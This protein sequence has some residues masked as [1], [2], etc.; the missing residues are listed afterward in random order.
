MIN[1]FNDLKESQN[2]E[3]IPENYEIKEL[4]SFLRDVKKYHLTQVDVEELKSELK[5]RPPKACI[6]RSV[7]KF[8]W[9]P[10]RFNLGKKQGR[11]IYIDIIQGEN[12]YLTALYQ[13]NDKKD[14]TFSEKECILQ[15]S[16][17]KN[18]KHD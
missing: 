10:K 6:G 1:F 4:S 16:R 14:L 7:Y 18:I 9:W 15:L 8:E 12:A 5:K 3:P 17:E 2:L 13:K 11:V